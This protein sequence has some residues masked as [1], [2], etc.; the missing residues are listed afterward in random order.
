MRLR[1]VLAICLLVPLSWLGSCTA[2]QSADWS[3]SFPITLPEGTVLDV[4]AGM[5]PSQV[6]AVL[7]AEAT[8]GVGTSQWIETDY[9]LK[10]PPIELLCMY[11]LEWSE[12]G[13]VVGE[14]LEKWMIRPSK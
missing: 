7:N 5:S 2:S 14:S 10:S 6:Q 8:P 12:D 1:A 3:S 11:A 9:W 4:R 13:R